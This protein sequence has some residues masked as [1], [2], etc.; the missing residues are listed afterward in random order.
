MQ[1][2]NADARIYALTVLAGH[3]SP[4][5]THHILHSVDRKQ[6]D[7]DREEARPADHSYFDAIARNVP[8]DARIV[9]VSHGKGQS[10]EGSHMLGYM[11]KHHRTLY[12]RIVRL[13]VADL[14]HTSVPQLLQLARDALPSATDAVDAI[15]D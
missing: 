7:A 1:I 4:K 13:I 14:P 5:E 2:D 3:Q 15:A 10:N 12:D 6:H 8:G 9:V 11:E